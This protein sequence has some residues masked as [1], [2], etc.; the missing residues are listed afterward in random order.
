MAGSGGQASA[1]GVVGKALDVPEAVP[2]P[3]T[4][5]F[6]IANR[7]IS[8]LIQDLILVSSIL[9]LDNY[10]GSISCRYWTDNKYR[11]RTVYL[12]R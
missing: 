7:G 8:N 12:G 3:V 11:Q 9:F 5:L 1:G 10:L 4:R 6:V 2:G